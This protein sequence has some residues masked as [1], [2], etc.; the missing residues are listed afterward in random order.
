MLR[1][2]GIYDGTNIILL[3]PVL[4]PPNTAV[5]V[6]VANG[7]GDAEQAYWS[8][9]LTSG[10]IKEIHPPVVVESSFVPVPSMGEPVSQTLLE[11]RR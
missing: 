10:L 2:K 1:I 6:V 7:D 9:L 11:E 8:Q 4:L 3:E 5:E